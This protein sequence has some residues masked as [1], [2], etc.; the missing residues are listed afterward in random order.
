M[1]IHLQHLKNTNSTVSVNIVDKSKPSMTGTKVTQWRYKIYDPKNNVA[2]DS[3]WVPDLSQ[4]QDYT[5]N[6]NSLSGRWTF[7]L[8]VKDDNNKESKVFQTYATAFLDEIPPQITGENSK[9]NVATITLTDTGMG[10]DDDGITFI[11]DNRGS[12]VEA[13]WVTSVR[14]LV[15]K[16]FSSRPIS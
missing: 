1:T 6:Q 12:G 15:T 5:F 9:R 8:T 7:E 14:I 2:Y 10:I 11:E 3:N 16:R 4:I 13:Y